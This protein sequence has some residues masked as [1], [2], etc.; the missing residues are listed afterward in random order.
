MASNDIHVPVFSSLHTDCVYHTFTPT[1]HT[2]VLLLRF[3]PLDTRFTRSTPGSLRFTHATHGCHV[4]GLVC[5][6]THTH[7][8]VTHC[9][10]P[11]LPTSTALGFY[12]HWVSCR[13][14]PA[15]APTKPPIPACLPPTCLPVFSA[16]VNSTVIAMPLVHGY[17]QV[18][19]TPMTLQSLPSHT[20]PTRAAFTTLCHTPTPPTPAP[21][22][23]TLP[24]PPPPHCTPPH[25]HTPT[26]HTAPLLPPTHHPQPWWAV[27]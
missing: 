3:A 7:L 25:H 9:R 16:F 27:A 20:L 6:H 5:T 26:L 18:W 17:C 24:H 12:L 2:R 1:P 11:T 19:T 14:T 8:R 21:T 15:H 4:Y 10:T 23:P 22:R 13:C